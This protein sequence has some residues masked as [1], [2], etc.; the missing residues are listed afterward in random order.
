VVRRRGAR[1]I[2]ATAPSIFAARLLFLV[3]LVLLGVL[4]EARALVKDGAPCLLT[5]FPQ[6]VRAF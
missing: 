4:T 5:L 1:A 3:A 2:I 6:V